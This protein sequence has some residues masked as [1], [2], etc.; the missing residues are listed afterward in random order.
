MLGKDL[1]EAVQCGDWDAT[2]ESLKHHPDLVNARITIYGETALHFA[3]HRG[4]VHIAEKLMEL[5][6]KEN[7]EIPTIHGR[8][9]LDEASRYGN[10]QMVECILRK[11]QNLTSI[12]TSGAIPLTWA[13]KCGYQELGRYLYLATPKEILVSGKAVHG[14]AA[15]SSAIYSGMWGKNYFFNDPYFIISNDVIVLAI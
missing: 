5:M 2:E 13:L 1:L 7:L 9:A 10:Y 3:V 6:P 15:C 4:Y 12:E 14:A 8:T 11:N